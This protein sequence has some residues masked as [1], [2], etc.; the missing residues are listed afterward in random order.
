M[1]ND[2]QP[3]SSS[4]AARAPLS[5]D[6]TGGGPTGMA[7]A[8]ALTDYGVPATIRIFE[9][10][11]REDGNRV[12]WRDLD[13]GNRR[14]EQI[15]TIQSNVW[16]TLPDQVQRAVFDCQDYTEMWPYGPDSPPTRGR[17]R[18]LP[19]R[20][21][22]D[23][24]LDLLST[25]TNVELVPERYQPGS[26]HGRHMLVICEGSHSPTREHFIER[27]GRP[28]PDLYRLNDG[29][30][31]EVILGMQIETRASDGE[32]VLITASQNRYLINTR[33]GRGFLNMRLTKDEASELVGLGEAG[34][35]D[36]LQGRPC[37]ML[38]ADRGFRCPT[39]ESLFKPCVDPT[40]FLWPRMKEGLRLF[41][42]E[43]DCLLAIVAFRFSLVNRPRF[44]AE[45]TPGTWGCLLGDAANAIHFW[46]GRGL[47]TGLK[48]ALSLA[49]CLGRRWNGGA[50]RAA[51]LC[52]HEGVMHMLQARE[53]DNRAWRTMEMRDEK[54][55]A[56]PIQERITRGLSGAC[57]RVTSTEQLLERMRAIRARLEGRMGGLPGDQV[58]EGRLAGLSERTLKILVETGPWIGADVGGPEVDV[59]ALLPLPR[60][61]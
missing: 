34:P 52:E 21:I 23:R 36:C 58:L 25:R 12:V 13:H 31:Q 3:T 53:I 4:E 1:N 48:S 2:T 39:H 57:D 29:P 30:L 50:L 44:V 20:N 18:N 24:L 61:K 15:V 32:G 8:L 17:P 11:W 10:R 22:E 28:H 33:W 55:Q 42:I 26:I 5:I 38:R 56:R 27:F 19:I 9:P 47:N 35:V 43:E 51:D 54:G 60:A 37:V 6:V 49:R 41:G 7:F 59:D 14:R 46:P 45:L 40:S 16:W